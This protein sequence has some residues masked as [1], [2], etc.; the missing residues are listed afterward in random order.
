MNCVV[1]VR[2]RLLI[3]SG[4]ATKSCRESKGVTGVI[5][6]PPR[7]K[8]KENFSFVAA[9]KL[10]RGLRIPPK[11][12]SAPA[13]NST[14]CTTSLTLRLPTCCAK[15]PFTKLL[16]EMFPAVFCS[17]TLETRIS[18]QLRH[19]GPKSKSLVDVPKNKNFLSERGLPK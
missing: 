13:K 5:A 17:G 4:V 14:P 3:A 15:P 7:K 12:T 10:G 11:R 6:P 16:T 8:L 9:A 1:E 18:P 2:F 19:R